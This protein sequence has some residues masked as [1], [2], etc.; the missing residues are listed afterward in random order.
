[1]VI[2]TEIEERLL[3]ELSQGYTNIAIAEKLNYTKNTVDAMTTRLYDK[4][5]IPIN[6]I[7]IRRVVAINIFYWGDRGFISNT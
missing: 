7:I 2:L 5:E 3:T 4:L 1:M 6:D